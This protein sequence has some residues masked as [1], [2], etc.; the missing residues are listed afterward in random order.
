MTLSLLSVHCFT[1]IAL[2]DTAFRNKIYNAHIVSCW[3]CGLEQFLIGILFS[4]VFALFLPPRATIPLPVLALCCPFACHS[5]HL[6]RMP[7]YNMPADRHVK[8]NS[9]R[10]KC[11]GLACGGC[12]P[13]YKHLCFECGKWLCLKCVLS[14]ARHKCLVIEPEPEPSRDESPEPSIAKNAG[15]ALQTSELRVALMGQES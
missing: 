5:K 14:N 15:A 12:K 11:K 1:F 7:Q 8:K 2:S 4:V 3:I 6:I 10:S 13:G 9:S